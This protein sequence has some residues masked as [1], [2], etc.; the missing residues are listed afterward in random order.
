MSSSIITPDDDWSIHQ[1]IEILSGAWAG[2]KGEIY[3]VNKEQ[4]KVKVLIN[5]WGNDTPVELNYNEIKPI[6]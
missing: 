4:K 1:I 5:F 6:K 2:F 3:S